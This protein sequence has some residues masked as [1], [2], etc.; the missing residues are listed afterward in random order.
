MTFWNSVIPLFIPDVGCFRRAAA[1]HAIVGSTNLLYGEL[2]NIPFRF[3]RQDSKAGS[4]G[5]KAGLSSPGALTLGETVDA[6]MNAGAPCGIMAIDRSGRS[7]VDVAAGYDLE[8]MH[9]MLLNCNLKPADSLFHAIKHGDVIVAE[10]SRQYPESPVHR[11]LPSHFGF[12]LNL[13]CPCSR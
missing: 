4:K 9:N 2:Y 12:L 8:L 7:V 10:V 3:S 13:L 5:S 1:L 6:M 11:S